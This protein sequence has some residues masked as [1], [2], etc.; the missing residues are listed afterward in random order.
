MIAC[1]PVQYQQVIDWIATDKLS[2]TALQTAAALDLPQWCLAAGFVRN[3][4]WDKLHGYAQRTALNDLD[5]VYFDP[6]CTEKQR[7]SEIEDKLCKDTGQPWSVK[8][9]ARMHLKHSD[10]PYRSCAEAISFWVEVETAIGV[11]IDTNQTPALVAP[12][13]V[14][15][16]LAG[17]ISC[18]EKRNNFPAFFHRIHTKKWL[19]IWPN[20]SVKS[21]T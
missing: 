13:G 12:F 15:S 20:L 4:V 19:S 7:D 5:L 6:S 16:L 18:N 14:E 8:N 2:M 17:H 21:K 10:K 11:T 1:K 3:L 9:Q